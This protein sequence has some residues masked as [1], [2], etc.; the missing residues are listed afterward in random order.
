[1]KKLILTA[2]LVATLAT[3][4]FSDTYRVTY[5]SHGLI[6]RIT[7]Q[8]ESTAEARRVVMAIIPG[9]LVTGVHRVK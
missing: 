4:A 2:A 6:Q 1:M 8:A 9:A 7:V 5:T 3:N